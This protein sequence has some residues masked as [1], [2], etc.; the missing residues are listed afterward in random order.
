M[1]K[2]LAVTALVGSSLRAPDIYAGDAAAAEALFREGR[3]LMDAGN[4][5]AACPE[6][7]ESYSQDPGTGTLLALGICQEHAGH[8]AS[9]WAT[10]AEVA[11]RAKADGRADREQA[12]REHM[13]A[14]DPKLSHLTIEVDASSS[15]VQ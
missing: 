4:Y 12:A 11:T 8:T 15:G 13:A 2:L 3:A 10:Y 5:A 1:R 14:L 9:A 6:L 7:E